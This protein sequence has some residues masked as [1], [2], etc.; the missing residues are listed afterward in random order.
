[1]SYKED[2]G[3]DDC[4][5]IRWDRDWEGFHVIVE[6]L[7]DGEAATMPVRAAAAALFHAL[8][9]ERQQEVILN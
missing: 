7:A 5:E 9:D 3:C 4:L 8:E 1:M 2:C 6:F